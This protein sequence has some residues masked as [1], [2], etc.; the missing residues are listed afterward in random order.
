M[1]PL[2]KRNLEVTFPWSGRNLA[3][4]EPFDLAPHGPDLQGRKPRSISKTAPPTKFRSSGSGGRVT[5]C[6]GA[7]NMFEYSDVSGPSK[8]LPPPLSP[9]FPLTRVASGVTGV[10][11]L[12]YLEIPPASG[13]AE[14][15]FV[16]KISRSCR[17][18][19]RDVEAGYRRRK[20]TFSLRVKVPRRRGVGGSGHACWSVGGF[21]RSKSARPNP[22]EKSSPFRRHFTRPLR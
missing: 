15:C 13:A 20:E 6:F 16:R 21:L 2:V 5:K 17:P 4:R 10:Q 19:Y 14:R 18:R 1:V 3:G 22:L 11:T 8:S 9:P 12:F 7:S